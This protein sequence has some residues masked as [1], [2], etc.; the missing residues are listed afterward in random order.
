MAIAG[1]NAQIS[2]TGMAK[3]RNPRQVFTASHQ[4]E[5]NPVSAPELTGNAANWA[6]GNNFV[7][8]QDRFAGYQMATVRSERTM[9]LD[10]AFAELEGV[11]DIA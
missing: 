5:G 7:A 10:A 3:P 8:N 4:P 11:F 2:A 1:A 9:S 6:T